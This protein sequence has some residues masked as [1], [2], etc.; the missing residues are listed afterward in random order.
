MNILG[1]T[2]LALTTTMLLA[3]CGGGGDS[4]G[5][6]GVTGPTT[7]TVDLRD[8]GSL[9]ALFNADGAQ[10]ATV[11]FAEA[12]QVSTDNPGM[13]AKDLQALLPKTTL[14]VKD[15]SGTIIATE[16]LPRQGGSFTKGQGCTWPVKVTV[17]EPTD[18]YQIQIA[19]GD[20]FQKSMN[21]NA[22]GG[23]QTVTF[24]F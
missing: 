6:S 22:K 10:C 19:H 15:A 14:T 7:L 9:D 18:V 13:A 3:G 2:A 4:S 16:D 12:L 20:A 11:N 8:T 21:A 1:K 23:D 17:K 5:S 24:T